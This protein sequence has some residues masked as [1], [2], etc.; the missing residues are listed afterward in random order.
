L[1]S[2][3]STVI[4]DLCGH[5]GANAGWNGDSVQ[6]AFTNA[7]LTQVC[8]TRSAHKHF[9]QRVERGANTTHAQTHSLS[10]SVLRRRL[11]PGVA[12]APP[13]GHGRLAGMSTP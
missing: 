1:A 13:R 4:P 8:I 12:P 11:G 5:S 7:A 2:Q 6:A 10:T 3:Q 9:P